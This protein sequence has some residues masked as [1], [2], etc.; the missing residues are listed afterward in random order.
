MDQEVS[1]T[2]ATSR[3][4]LNLSAAAVHLPAEFPDKATFRRASIQTA[5][6]NGD[7]SKS[8]FVTA[9]L[10]ERS[11]GLC[12]ASYL[13]HRA[14]LGVLAGVVS[15]GCLPGADRPVKDVCNASGVVCRVRCVPCLLEFAPLSLL[16]ES[17]FNI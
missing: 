13:M 2:V 6:A 7:V 11:G 3:V 10:R 5:I 17:L 4:K 1:E 12:K 9:A 14:S 16:C 8:G 15:Q